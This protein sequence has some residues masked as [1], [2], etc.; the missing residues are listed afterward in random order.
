MKH[1]SGKDV[2]RTYDQ[3]PLLREGVPLMTI[4]AVAVALSWIHIR[5]RSH[6][7]Q[8]PLSEVHSKMIKINGLTLQQP[9]FE[10]KGFCQ[11]IYSRM[12]DD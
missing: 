10:H 2:W 11:T 9:C 7:I 6:I 5:I 12:W 1:E 3:G 8:V 4:G